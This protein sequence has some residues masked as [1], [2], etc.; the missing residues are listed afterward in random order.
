MIT[1]QAHGILFENEIHAFLKQTKY[2]VLLN[3]KA[4]RQHDNTITAIDHLLIANNMCFCFQDKWL[5]TTISNSNFN[6]FCKCVEKI[7]TKI[8]TMKIYGIYISNND[9]SS[10][11][12]KQLED[13]NNKTAYTNIEYVK[14]NHTNKMMLFDKLHKFLH[15]YHV[16][17]YDKDNDCIML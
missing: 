17:I 14:I 5:N 16:F 6:H 3:E 8:N 15:A 4:I 10:I 2:D 12:N 1:A 13:E 9:F 7:A 11:A